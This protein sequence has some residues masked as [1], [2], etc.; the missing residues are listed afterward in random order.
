MSIMAE[1]IGNL[2]VPASRN[3]P[4]MAW[5]PLLR[6]YMQSR[7]AACLKPPF[8]VASGVRRKLQYSDRVGKRKIWWLL[9]EASKR[10]RSNAAICL[11]RQ[12]SSARRVRLRH[13][14]VYQDAQLRDTPTMAA[15]Q[16]GSHQP[17]IA[18]TTWAPVIL[19][20]AAWGPHIPD[21][22]GAGW[23]ASPGHLDNPAHRRF[24]KPSR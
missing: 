5:L 23:A 8:L 3:R 6:W 9:A 17:V 7:L 11:R 1:N 20:E 22:M 21:V 18:S 2:F 14:A 24:C 15:H 16:D 19:V 12:G 13:A 10:G 4:V